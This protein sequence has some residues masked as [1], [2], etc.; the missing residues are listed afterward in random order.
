MAPAADRFE[1][2]VKVQLLKRGTMFPMRAQKL[3]DLY[4]AHES[5]DVLP[6]AERQKL[7]TQIFRRSLDDVWQ[8]TVRYF[9]ERDPYQVE[10]ANRDPK[11]KMALVFRWYLGL[12]SRWSNA[13]E[14]GRELDYQIWCGPSMGAF[15]TW[16]KGTYLEAPAQRYV[17]DVAQHLMRGAAYL[18]RIQHLRTQ[19]VDIAASLARYIP[20]RH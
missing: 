5:L 19:M 12:S 2:G 8:D 6:D 16:V 1:M 15:N 10:R 7:E 20:E 18:Y 14:A 4:Q 9:M 17:V 13:G 11:R 3:F